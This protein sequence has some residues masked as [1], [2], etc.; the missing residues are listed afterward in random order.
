MTYKDLIVGQTVNV[1]IKRDNIDI[2]GFKKCEILGINF[3]FDDLAIVLDLRVVEDTDAAII[4]EDSEFY[5]ATEDG[6]IITVE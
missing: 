3:D 1:E 6:E 4:T 5:L 2:L